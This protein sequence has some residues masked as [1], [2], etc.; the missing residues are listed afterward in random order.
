MRFWKLINAGKAA[1]I[2]YFQYL[3]TEDLWFFVIRLAFGLLPIKTFQWGS[4]SVSLVRLEMLPIPFSRSASQ[5]LICIVE[6]GTLCLYGL[7]SVYSQHFSPVTIQHV[8]WDYDKG[9]SPWTPGDINASRETSLRMNHNV[10][11]K[12]D[13][14]DL[15]WRW[16]FKIQYELDNKVM[17]YC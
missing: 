5:A 6:H 12:V 16:R 3:V 15:F 2:V 4:L 1:S 8:T 10:K 13:K 7:Y 11:E 9:V 14:S 17:Q